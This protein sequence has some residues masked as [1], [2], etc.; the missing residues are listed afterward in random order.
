MAERTRGG[1]RYYG[2]LLVLCALAF[3]SIALVHLIN[4]RALIW[5]PDGVAL[6]YNFFVYEGEWLRGIVSSI[7]AGAPEVP[8]YSFEMGYGADVL[9]TMGGCL[10]DPF[11]L[12]SVFCPP[13]AA[14]YVF[15]ALIFVRF[16]L[17]ALAYSWYSFN[18]GRGRWATLFG[19]LCYVLCGYV[20][21]W[22]VL[23]H[24]NFLNF[25][26]LLPLIL[27]GA[28][29]IMARKS[30]YLFI[31]GFAFLLLFSLYFSYMMLIITLVYCLLAFFLGDAERS[32][33]RFF[34]L[35]GQFALYVLLAAL[36]A[37]FV[38]V[39]MFLV[40]TSMGR[41]D[42]VREIPTWE[43]FAFYWRYGANLLGGYL[44]RRSL[45]MG[46][47]PMAAMVAFLAAR[48]LLDREVWRPWA[49]GLLLCLAGSMIPAVGSALN[50]FGYVTDRWLIAFG[51]CIAN[52]ATL[53]LPVLRSFRRR[54]WVA[55][56]ALCGLLV[57]WAAVD[58]V[59]EPSVMTITAVLAFG[60]AALFVAAL[61]WAPVKTAGAC[62]SV[63]VIVGSGVTAALVN[64][65]VGD[66][67]AAQFI[68]S[69]NAR[70]ISRTVPFDRI[71]G[72]VDPAY[73]VDRAGGY[74][75]RNQT[76]LAGVKGFDFFSSFY[77]QNVDDARYALG[78]SS[79]WSNYVYNG[80]EG[81]F[82]LDNLMGA[83][84][85]I[86]DEA[87]SNP[88]G[89]EIK[90]ESRGRAPYGYEKIQDLGNSN[91]R[92]PFALY[93]SALA[94][95]LAFTYDTA[96]SESEFERLGMVQRQE[97]LTHAC[98]L[99]DEALAA[100]AGVPTDLS[101]LVQ[102]YDIVDQEGVRFTDE[103]LEVVEPDGKLTLKTKEGVPEAENYVVF[104]RLLFTPLSLEDRRAI[105]GNPV[106][107]NEET[108]ETA[109]SWDE[110]L[111]TE[112]SRVSIIA[113]AGGRRVEL[114]VATSKSSTYGGKV[115]W[116]LN[117]GYAKKAVKKFRL[118]F[119]TPGLYTWDKLSVVSQPVGSIEDNLRKLKEDNRASVR[120]GTNRF[121]VAVAAEEGQDERYTFVSVPYSAGW[122]A[123]LD[124]Q[125]VDIL[126]ANTGFMAVPM[127]GSAHELVM[128]YCT[129]G[130]K[131]G[132][133]CTAVGVVGVIVLVV[134][135]RQRAKRQGRK[136]Q[137]EQQD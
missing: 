4:G 25:A 42:L 27:W 31:G 85:F 134:F 124:G 54:Q 119:E 45:V 11:N 109:T 70:T 84:Y 19:A 9:A 37:G 118:I 105:T 18:R 69:G 56:G 13:E 98:V 29:R 47:V 38:A 79:H 127:D 87:T 33:K 114:Q 103:G 53:V 110:L 137:H 24:P 57:L 61:R 121:D 86:V 83:R 44:G 35:L 46:I 78:V 3:A 15:E 60:V 51:F 88:E 48:R 39:P 120:F 49:V 108:G 80:V 95:P 52:A 112:P 132:L 100:D 14:E 1:A 55:F 90:E 92:G 5:N 6:Y 36:L 125:P 133:G 101:T 82:A 126:R 116:A 23:R 107:V 136:E 65:S 113:K 64:S 7:L 58:A 21:Y 123:T 104:D 72:G 111:W 102:D 71:E 34:G 76:P 122:S 66:S 41:V 73:R 26:I 8:L 77:N 20:V 17:A 68:T 97:L 99:P 96:C 135:R 16:V 2:L 32:A 130:L 91:K 22:G 115:N 50:G 131:I 93:E 28:D 63:L 89:V 59:C 129:P 106:I 12:L 67:Y 10:N 40:L 94:L 62:L 43:P 81:R 128:S 74:G 30:P 75:T 117:M